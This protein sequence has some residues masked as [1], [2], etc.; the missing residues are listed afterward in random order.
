MWVYNPQRHYVLFLIVTQ[1]NL[2]F[3]Q[4]SWQSRE[5]LLLLLGWSY[6]EM[7]YSKNQKF[8]YTFIAKQ[9]HINTSYLF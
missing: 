4:F 1:L 6:E 5:K 7:N 2:I 3:M 8:A 9:L